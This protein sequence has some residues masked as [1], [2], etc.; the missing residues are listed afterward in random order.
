MKKCLF[1][2][3][4][5]LFPIIGGD[6]IRTV[7]QL[8]L[9]TE[10][11]NVDVIY[12]SPNAV[13]EEIGSHN[14]RIGK[15][16]RFQSG[17]LRNYL[18]ALRFLFNRLPIQVNYYFDRRMYRKISDIIDDYDAVFCNNIRTAEYVRKRVGIVKYID[19]VDAISMNYEKAKEEAWGLKKLIYAIDYARC[20]N[21]E[22]E[23][24]SAFDSCA[25]ISEVDNNYL[26]SCQ[27]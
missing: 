20:R 12:L 15:E 24:I 25:V 17:R 22:Q 13:D 10:R 11:F 5:P 2:S 1:I 21:Y 8:D 26:K 7:Q 3:S 27:I 18:Q 16:W 4:R 19:F 23:C 14:P 6:Q 9:L